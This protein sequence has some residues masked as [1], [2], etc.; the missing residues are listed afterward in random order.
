[1]RWIIAGSCEE[2][3][4]QELVGDEGEATGDAANPFWLWWG[5]MRRP[6][7]RS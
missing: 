4:V 1:M 7:A 2:A 3:L 5:A 6:A